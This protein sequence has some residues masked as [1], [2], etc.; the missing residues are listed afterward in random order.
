MEGVMLYHNCTVIT[1]NSE[2]DIFKNG[3]FVVEDGQFIDVGKS[4]RI[5]KSYSGDEKKNLN[6]KIVIPGL[7]NTHTHVPMVLFRGLADDLPLKEWLENYIWPM[8]NKMID[9]DFIKWGSQLAMMEM[10]STGTTA[11]ADMYFYEEEVARLV[12]SIGMRASLGEGI[13]QFETPDA[14]KPEQN[15]ERFKMLTQRW[16]NDNNIKI[17]MCAHSPYTCNKDLLLKTKLLADKYDSMYH[18][19]LAE[20]KNEKSMIKENESEVSPV[21]YLNDIGILDENV[22]A[23][24]AVWTD[25]AD[26][27]I[28]KENKVSVV[29]NA[30]SNLKLGSGIAPISKY[31]DAGIN[32][33]VGTDG[34]ASNNTLN[35]F[36][37]MRLISLLHKGVNLEPTILPS[38]QVLKMAT[39]NGAKSLG[40]D[41]KIGSIEENKHADFVVIN[42]D[43]VNM[44]P[45]YNPV[46][47]L[48]YA[49]NGS[50]VEKVYVGGELLYENKEFKTINKSEVLENVKKISKKIVGNL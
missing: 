34:A 26:I 29:H 15:I 4:E 13:I 49:A 25:K 20:T 12:K 18:I 28:L 46:S 31:L 32:V 47:H 37:E 40:W 45:M 41:D 50:E 1:M 19:H 35:M 17:S 7:I 22:L 33:S 43:S 3:A 48:I 42:K 38:E 2:N 14:N 10:I 21:M 23:A 9:K 8:E 36:N 39:I 11:F 6:S 5:I 30:S 16:H 27:D 24:H 44:K